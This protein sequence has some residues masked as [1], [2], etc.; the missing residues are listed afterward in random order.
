MQCSC[1]L[2]PRLIT[3]G[4]TDSVRFRKPLLASV[5]TQKREERWKIYF[6]LWAFIF[7]TNRKRF[8][9]FK[10]IS[11]FSH[12]HSFPFSNC[13][14]SL[15]IRGV[16]VWK[17]YKILFALQHPPHAYCCLCHED[18]DDDDVDGT[19]TS[20]FFCCCFFLKTIRTSFLSFAIKW[21]GIEQK[22]RGREHEV[23]NG[24]QINK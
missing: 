4:Y 24:N 9:H 21:N 10:I 20:I 8:L 5:M 22:E 16:C 2:P 15:W 13:V 23:E 3:S 18:D 7:V 17:M 12:F 14:L 11:P 1:A 6:S 19:T